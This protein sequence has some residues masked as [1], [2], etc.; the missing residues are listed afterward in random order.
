MRLAERLKLR[1]K[2][3][4]LEDPDFGSLVFIYVPNAPEDSYWEAEWEFPP[5]GYEISIALP[6]DPSGPSPE[7]R[8][9]YLSRAA[10]FEQTMNLVRPRLDAVFRDSLGRPLARDPWDDVKLA[11]IHFEDLEAELVSWDV[12]F[13]TLGERWLGITIPIVGG[14]AEEAEVDT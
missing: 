11:G 7:S 12:S 10:E 2:P 4:R 6:G 9:F 3:P 14:V 1:F 8:E 13:E 5:T